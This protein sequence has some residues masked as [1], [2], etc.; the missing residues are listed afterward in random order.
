MEKLHSV[1][2]FKLRNKKVYLPDFLKKHEIGHLDDRKKTAEITE[3][4]MKYTTISPLMAPAEQMHT[5]LFII[6]IH[7][8]KCLDIKR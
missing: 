5:D 6:K 1:H 3:Q 7:I 4:I 8:R 2:K